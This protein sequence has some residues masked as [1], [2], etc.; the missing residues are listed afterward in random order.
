MKIFLQVA[1]CITF[2]ALQSTF[3]KS[4]DRLTTKKGI[5]VSGNFEMIYS[6]VE[7]VVRDR[8]ENKTYLA[9]EVESI[10]LGSGEKLFS[11]KVIFLN[12]SESKTTGKYVFLKE[13]LRGILKLYQYKGSEFKFVVEK[14]EEVLVLQEVPPLS[15]VADFSGFKEVLLNFTSDCLSN[16]IVFRAKL[17]KNNLVYLVNKYN[18]CIDESYVPLSTAEKKE[19]IFVLGGSFGINKAEHSLKARVNSVSGPKLG[20]VD[21]EN[22]ESIGSYFELNFQ[23]NLF[24]RTDFFVS[25]SMAH[26]NFEVTLTEVDDDFELTNLKFSELDF[27]FGLNYYKKVIGAV[28][29]ELNPGI[30]LWLI[31]SE[32]ILLATNAVGSDNVILRPQSK[33]KSGFGLFLKGSVELSLT[34]KFAL[35]SS[36]GKNFRFEKSAL[37]SKEDSANY[38][39]ELNDVYSLSFG[40]RTKIFT[41]NL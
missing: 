2:F 28:S 1:L 4:Q 17:E 24:N 13:L 10:E 16:D 26:K 35:Y 38:Y 18:E 20:D 5:V 25:G 23:K 36:F 33:S 19:S 32:G 41:S 8:T 14:N 37:I 15:G 39:D 3:L 7:D 29:L 22:I 31:P 11:K 27:N 6:G 12:D 21:Q 9:S 34:N 40:I 30:Y